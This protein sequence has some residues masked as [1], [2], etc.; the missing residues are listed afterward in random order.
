MSEPGI[1]LIDRPDSLAQ[2]AYRSIRQALRN[3]VLVH[4]EFYSESELAQSMGISRTPVREA[5]IELAREGLVEIVPQRGFR[6]RIL[7]PD[8]QREVFELRTVLESYVA[9]RLARQATPDQVAQLREVLARQAGLVDEASEFLGV[10]E[11]FHL[12]MPRLVGLERTHEMLATLRGA[13]W[14]IGS[15]ALSLPQRGP[16]VLSEHAAIVDAIAD[17]DSKGAARALRHHIEQTA[18]A[19]VGLERRSAQTTM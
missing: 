7:G 4:G 16:A 9:E 1:P 12:L 5:L 6:L 13:M 11:E 15:T 10:D 17:G 2:Q 14:L 19:A 8:D 18:L 3:Q